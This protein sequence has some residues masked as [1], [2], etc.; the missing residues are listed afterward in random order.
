MITGLFPAGVFLIDS[1]QAFCVVMTLCH[2][3]NIDM[4]CYAFCN[5]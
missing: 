2:T 3:Q 5:I 4:E 1:L